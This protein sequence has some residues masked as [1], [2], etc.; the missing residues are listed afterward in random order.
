MKSQARFFLLICLTV[1]A[2][3][4]FAQVPP[5]PGGPGGPMS[6]EEMAKMETKQ[7]KESLKLSDAQVSA[8]EKISLKYAGIMEDI[9]K[10]SNGDFTSMEKKM[11]EMEINKSAELKKVLTAQQFA[12]YE[13]QV[14]E[15][16][17]R[18]KQ[19]GGPGMR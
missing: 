12:D 10:N 6:K 13:K 14:K 9:F 11:D 3:I 16:K 18:M 17:E 5:G 4:M 2:S 15:R 19:G 8:V 7:M 1:I